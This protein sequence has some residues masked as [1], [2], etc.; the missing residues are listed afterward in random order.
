MNIGVWFM[1]GR[2][3]FSF[4]YVVGTLIG[5]PQLRAYGFTLS[6]FVDFLL[7]EHIF[8]AEPCVS[9]FLLSL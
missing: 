1:L 4:G 6:I 8:L 2:V 9:T 3:L 7:L 5:F